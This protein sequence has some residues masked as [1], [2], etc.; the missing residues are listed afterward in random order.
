M[1]KK[2]IANSSRG[3][4]IKRG[5]WI[6]ET[7]PEPQALMMRVQRIKMD[8]ALADLPWPCGGRRKERRQRAWTLFCS[9]AA[10]ICALHVSG[11]HGW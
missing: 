1:R 7:S 11:C 10:L 5:G 8:Q 6:G 4:R 3:K 2:R 9:Q